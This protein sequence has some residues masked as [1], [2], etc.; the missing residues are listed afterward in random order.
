M[1][2]LHWL[3]FAFS[4]SHS[5]TIRFRPWSTIVTGNHLDHVKQKKFQKLLR[6][7]APFMFIFDS[8]SGT[9]GPTS[10]FPNVHE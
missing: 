3:L 6:R 8:R 4:P 2:P 5:D 7:L 1:P 10:A 9:L